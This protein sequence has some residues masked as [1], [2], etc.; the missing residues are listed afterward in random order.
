VEVVHAVEHEVHPRD[1]GGDG[2]ELL[3]VEAGRAGVAAAA[4]HLGQAGDEHAA[5]AAGRVVDALAR[6]RLQHLRHQVD[7]RAVGVELLRRVAAVV[8]ELLDQVLVAVA[9][10][11]LGHVREAERVLGEVLD[12]VLERASGIWALSVQGALPKTP[13][14]RSGWRP[15][16][17][18]TRSAA[19]ARHL[20]R[21]A[22][23]LP[24]RALGDHE[25]VVGGGGRVALVAVSSKA[26]W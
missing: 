3:P 8:G 24:V 19:P 16:W 1:G 21:G 9:E 13:C 23:V 12:Q 11:V 26:C 7:Q 5:G 18:G 14:S 2:D 6:L 17:P 15:R 10:L 20:R 4:L 22:H 25:A